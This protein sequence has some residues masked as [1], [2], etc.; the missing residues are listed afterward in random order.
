[1]KVFWRPTLGEEI[2][3][4]SPNRKKVLC[5]WCRN[6]GHKT[7]DILK[8]EV[9][10]F[11][12]KKKVPINWFRNYKITIKHYF[13]SGRID[14][15]SKTI[16]Q[17]TTRKTFTQL[18]LCFY[19]KTKISNRILKRISISGRGFQNPNIFGINLKWPPNLTIFMESQGNHWLE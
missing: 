11:H 4:I 12:E 9:I 16:Q 7:N 8:V 19:I 14:S 10:C 17:L 2:H 13:R 6:W 3:C 18:S 1:M 5:F 15:L